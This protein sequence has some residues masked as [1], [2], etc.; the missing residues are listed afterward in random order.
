M[1]FARALA[2]RSSIEDPTL[3]LTSAA[4]VEW[5]HGG[6]RTLADVNVTEKR[7][8]GLTA[9][10]RGIALMSGTMAALPFKIYKRDTRERVTQR[11]VLDNPNPRQTPFEFWQT[12]YAN[13]I[14]WGTGYARKFRNGADVVTELWA[15]HPS[16][17]TTKVT[18]PSAYRP[19]G[20]EFQVMQEDGS[21]KPLSSWEIMRL[22]FLAPNG[23]EGLSPIRAAR[24]SL[25]TGIAAE[26]HSARFYGNGT[27][28]SGVLNVK[29]KLAEGSANRLKA[30]WQERMTG[31]RHAFD[32]A[33]LD[34]GAEFQ[35]ISVSPADAQLL[36]SRKFTVVEIARMLGLPPHLLGDVERSTSWGTGIEQQAIGMVVYTLQSW[37]TM[38]EQ[39][40]TREILPGGWSSGSWYAEY[41]L[42]GLLRG[43]SSARASFYAQMIQ[44]GIMNRNEA[45]VRENLEPADG[46]DEFITP[47]NMTIISVDGKPQSLA[48]SDTTAPDEAA[49]E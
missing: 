18:P 20:L 45:R 33:V 30:Q 12:T 6:D 8:F 16:L 25:G 21:I 7:I 23:V 24:E 9:Y 4:L 38:V 36:E 19:D 14:G 34:N 49:Q 31:G 11:T 35:N 47:S 37:L 10:F 48:P 28:L 2:T 22:P 32:I 15:V 13:A 17:V 1:T 41:G 27:H 44:W 39:R 46:L 40:V 26:N 43:D 3:P 29:Q 42:E 5:L